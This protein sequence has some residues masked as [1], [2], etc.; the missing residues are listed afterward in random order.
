MAKR[1]NKK[2]KIQNKAID[3]LPTAVKT[4]K[5]NLLE[6][7]TIVIALWGA[8]LSTWI[9]VQNRVENTPKLF[10][11]MDAQAKGR[12]END[13]LVGDIS[14]S[15]TNIGSKT[16]T[17]APSLAVFLTDS[18]SGEKYKTEAYFNSEDLNKSERF[19]SPSPVTLKVGESATAETSMI[20]EKI[21]FDPMDYHSVI[22]QL[23]T[24]EKFVAHFS[25]EQRF[26]I[27]RDSNTNEMI[28]WSTGSIA[29][30]L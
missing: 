12:L 5:I 9:Y 16:I 23:S 28:G 21:A 14:I 10:I 6:F 29:E 25:I 22:L 1:K 8:I 20:S 13:D 18:R 11:K 15:V 19:N 27:K 24:G 30:Q 3:P 4:S 7:I 2:S 26:S 17:V